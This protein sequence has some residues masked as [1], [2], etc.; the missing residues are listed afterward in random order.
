MGQAM[1]DLYAA[2]G[3]RDWLARAMEAGRFI[4]RHFRADDGGFI[5]TAARESGEGVFLKPVKALEEHTQLA[6]F[7]NLLHRYSGTAQFRMMADHAMRY[8][9]GIALAD[10][11][12]P[13]PGL[14]QADAE[15]A[16]EPVHI[17]IVG[18]KDDA[19]AKALH[20]AARRYPAIYK[21]LDWWDMREG[22]L[23]NPDVQYPDLGEAAASACS[24]SLCSLPVF[25]AA[26]LAG[27]V[28]T[29]LAQRVAVRE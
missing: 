6:R 2:T 8:M 3:E 25:D 27:T 21:R 16:I 29:M 4:D 7:A 17:T 13:W 22:P 10:E 19:R 24:N 1:I 20:E 14:L 5:T 15:F 18:H 11:G 9:A 12:R 26:N 28:E 23:P